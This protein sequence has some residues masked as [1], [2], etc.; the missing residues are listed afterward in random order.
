M[1]F[2]SDLIGIPEFVS[3]AMENW[4]LI[5]YKETYILYSDSD[6]SISDMQRITA[7][8]SHE[9]AHMVRCYICDFFELIFIWLFNWK[10]FGNLV[11]LN[12]WNDLW[13]NEGFASYIEYEGLYHMNFSWSLFSLFTTSDLHPALRAD[14]QLSARPVVKSVLTPNQITSMFD[15]FSYSKG[16][17]ILYMIENI[18]GKDAF[19]TCCRNYLNRNKFATANTSEMIKH[20]SA[21][22]K[23]VRLFYS[24][25]YCFIIT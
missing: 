4:G 17:S 14:S 7:V 5:T 19:R 12:W 15:T 18:I 20:F 2:F 22:I 24:S 13:L 16:A 10:W 9:L 3:G 21:E 23:K 1:D 11:T 8:I 25:F 6:S